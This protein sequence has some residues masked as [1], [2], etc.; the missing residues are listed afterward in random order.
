[1][2]QKWF[3]ERNPQLLINASVLTG[4]KIYVSGGCAPIFRGN[5]MIGA[6]GL[7]E[8][9]LYT[10]AFMG[11]LGMVLAWFAATVLR[12]RP[13]RFPRGAVM[14]GFAV[15]AALNV[16]NPDAL[17][18]R[19]NLRRAERT[20]KLDAVYLSRLS[21]DAAPA[22]AG[23]LRRLELAPLDACLLREDLRDELRTRR[24]WRGWNLGR[25]RAAA[26][27]RRTPQA[28]P[29]AGCREQ[30]ALEEAVDAFT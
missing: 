11:W 18:A 5:E 6:Y 7:T 23:G 22:V 24:D 12:G 4:G 27:A 29:V 10:T 2:I 8:L 3:Q 20:G 19:T 17:I 26:I 30:R 1:V 14:S 28:A 16:L 21:A 9:R 15:V 13:G 25:S